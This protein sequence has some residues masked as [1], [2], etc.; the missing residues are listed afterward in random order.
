MRPATPKSEVLYCRRRPLLFRASSVDTLQAFTKSYVP[1][2][3]ANALTADAFSRGVVRSSTD[4]SVYTSTTPGGRMRGADIAFYKHRA[5]YHTPDDS[6]RGMGRDG[7]REALW[8]MLEIVRG[9]GGALVNEDANKVGVG[10]GKVGDGEVMQETEGAVYFERMFRCILFCLSSILTSFASAVY[11]NFLIVFT[12]RILLAVHICLLAGGPII[13]AIFAF[14]LYRQSMIA[15][16]G[17]T[18]RRWVDNVRGYG[19]FW[20]TLFITFGAQVGLI[21]GF[22]KLNPYVSGF[23]RLVSV[24][25]Q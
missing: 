9:A 6:V 15:R 16:R 20:L 11:A 22:I 10:H 5:R 3:H 18:R 13:V 1:H 23:S 24:G 12:S 8:A 14:L 2:P 25:L 17:Q 19:R 21:I 4:Y 7:A